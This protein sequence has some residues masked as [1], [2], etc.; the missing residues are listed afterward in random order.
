MSH[1]LLSGVCESYGSTCA[2]L[3]ASARKSALQEGLNSGVVLHACNPEP[4]PR[5]LD[6]LLPRVQQV[7]IDRRSV[8]SLRNLPRVSRTLRLRQM[9]EILLARVPE[10]GL[11]GLRV[12]SRGSSHLLC[13]AQNTFQCIVHMRILPRL[14]YLR[15]GS[16][17]LAALERLFA[18]WAGPSHPGPALLLGLKVRGLQR[19]DDGVLADEDWEWLNCEASA[20]LERALNSALPEESRYLTFCASAWFRLMLTGLAEERT[21][22]VTKLLAV[23]V[24]RGHV[25]YPVIRKALRFRRVRVMPKSARA[26]LARA[27]ADAGHPFESLR[28]HRDVLRERALARRSMEQIEH[29]IHD[30][31]CPPRVAERALREV[32]SYGAGHLARYVGLAPVQSLLTTCHTVSSSPS[33]A[34]HAERAQQLLRDANLAVAEVQ[35]ERKRPGPTKPGS[36]SAN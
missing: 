32:S 14:T 2:R 17:E 31:E 9:A 23:A 16:S 13:G 1:L 18:S 15:E 22:S 21:A 27:L 30:D 36:A 3:R 6:R 11:H 28:L 20:L 7:G 10:K 29:L 12:S 4:A 8:L 24:A 19:D 33:A 25:T 26:T 35:S 34:E 5:L